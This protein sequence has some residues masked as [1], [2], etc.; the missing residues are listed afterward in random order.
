[1]LKLNFNYYFVNTFFSVSENDILFSGK[2][3]LLWSYG[4]ENLRMSIKEAE[5][6]GIMKQID[7]ES[8]ALK[9]LKG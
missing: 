1:M 6:F 5:K 8:I 3:G 7:I 2:N 4:K 9:K